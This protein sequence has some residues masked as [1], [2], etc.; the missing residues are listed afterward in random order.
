MISGRFRATEAMAPPPRKA[1]CLSAVH[2]FLTALSSLEAVTTKSHKSFLHI[3]T[4]SREHHLRRTSRLLRHS[5]IPFVSP[6]LPIVALSVLLGSQ[7]HTARYVLNV[8]PA[9]AIMSEFLGLAFPPPSPSITRRDVMLTASRS[10]I[11]LIS[12]SDIRYV[13]FADRVTLRRSLP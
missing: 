4:C 11:S 13:C 6:V 9:P 7:P 8:A 5:S 3:N 2:Q 1:R 12:K 10:R